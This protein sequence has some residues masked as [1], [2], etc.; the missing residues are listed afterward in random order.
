MGQA[1]S[2]TFIVPH[3]NRCEITEEQCDDQALAKFI[4]VAQQAQ[5]VLASLTVVDS[6]HLDIT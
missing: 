3:N 2:T 5:W 6:S 1:L 4:T